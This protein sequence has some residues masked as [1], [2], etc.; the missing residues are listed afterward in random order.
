MDVLEQWREHLNM[1]IIQSNFNLSD[2]NVIDISNKV[3][4]LV[5]NEMQKR[6]Q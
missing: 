6:V 2:A 5:L 4:I 1:A 3:D